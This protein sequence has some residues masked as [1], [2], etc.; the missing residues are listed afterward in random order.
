MTTMG[1]QR[2][3]DVSEST[4]RQDASSTASPNTETPP[5]Q[6]K[7]ARLLHDLDD[8]LLLD[9]AE[10]YRGL[11]GELKTEISRLAEAAHAT[12][13]NNH[14][15]QLTDAVTALISK[16]LHQQPTGAA[17]HLSYTAALRSRLPA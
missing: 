6:L 14:V 17:V 10:R 12:V 5:P 1:S 4:L 3:C 13:D 2:T 8:L 15:W 9:G 11:W 7:V 16:Q